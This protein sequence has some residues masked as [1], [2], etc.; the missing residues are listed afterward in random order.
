MT[1]IRR[2][3]AAVGGMALFAVAAIAIGLAAGGPEVRG[4]RG[5]ARF[6]LLPAGRPA[7]TV[8]SPAVAATP[9]LSSDPAAAGDAGIWST[10]AEFAPPE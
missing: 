7:A 4:D 3:A 6:N 5:D 10:P 8:T 2:P 1:L 9:V